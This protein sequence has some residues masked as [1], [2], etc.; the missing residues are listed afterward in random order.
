MTTSC[1]QQR[2]WEEYLPGPP[3]GSLFY[4]IDAGYSAVD[5][6]L[7]WGPVNRTI[8]PFTNIAVA[9]AG[10]EVYAEF[11]LQSQTWI[12][13]DLK[14]G[15]KLW[16]PTTPYNSSLGYYNFSGK[17]VIG[18]GNLY[19]WSYGG[20]VYCYD[21]KTGVEKW[22]WYAGNAGFDTPYGTSP[23]G[24]FGG[25]D[26]ADGKLYVAAGHDYTPPVFKGSKL[27]ALNATTGEEIWDSLCFSV[28]SAPAIADGI[29]VKFNGYDNQIYAYGKG[30]TA[31]TVT[32]PSV[33]V[34]T[35]TPLTIKGTIIDVSAGTQQD[36]V[37]SNFPYGLPVV[38]TKA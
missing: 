31:I 12:G 15:Q 26:L 6:H 13:Y 32:A 3:G 4:R 30:P 27:Y 21:V 25:Y 19:T 14:T 9:A 35:T 8:T 2:K 5:G 17:G 38:S 16:G 24:V 22:G 37:K 36:A 18:Y 10:E 28:N 11:T 23:L 34:S 1:S 20:E 29:L 33:G 7:I